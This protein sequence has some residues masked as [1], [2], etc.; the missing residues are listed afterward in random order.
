MDLKAY[1]AELALRSEAM[2]AIHMAEM[3]EIEAHQQMLN[4]RSRWAELSRELQVAEQRT[5]LAEERCMRAHSKIASYEP[6]I[7]RLDCAF[8][9]I[10]RRL[11]DF[12]PVISLPSKR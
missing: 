6:Y 12:E 8:A 2:D 5:K 1:S 10:T 11:T 4:S 3:R 9:R 7:R